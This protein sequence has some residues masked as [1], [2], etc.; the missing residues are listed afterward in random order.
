MTLLVLND[1][2]R[3]D[4]TYIK[5]KGVWKYLYRA[6]NSEGNTL[7]FRPSAKRNSKA[8]ARFLRKVLKAQHTQTPRVIIVDKNGAY[9]VAMD[10]L[11]QDEVIGKATELR[12]SKYLKAT[13]EGN[14]VLARPL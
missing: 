11:K 6:V 14:V 2:W 5:I 10:T 9:P 13:V 7:D 8:A 12:Q 4:E 3:V 1:A